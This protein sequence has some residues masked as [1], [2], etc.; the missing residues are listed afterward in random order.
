MNRIALMVLRNILLV[1]GAYWKLCHYAK[2]T[3]EYSEEEKYRH[4]QYIF[5][6]AVKSGNIDLQVSGVEN[7]P[8]ENGFMIYSNHQRLF[9]IMAISKEAAHTPNNALT[10]N[11]E[12][13]ELRKR[14]REQDKEIRRLKE[15]NE[16]PAQIRLTFH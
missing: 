3:E 4:I 8:K 9:D 14:V 12:L 13:I 6:R 16:F 2:H 5:R 11:E 1:P 15:E 7:I 10:L